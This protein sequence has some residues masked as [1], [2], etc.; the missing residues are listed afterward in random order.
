ME[1][2]Y[3]F[4][5]EATRWLQ[6]TYPS[7]E[8]F[9]QF[10]S[11]IGRFEFYL[12]FLTLLYWCVDKRLGAT[13]VYL[14]ILSDFSNAIIKH[15]FRDPRP[16]WL[17]PAVGL[18]SEDSYGI[19]SGH[20]QS[21]TVVYFLIAAWARRSWGW[22]VAVLLA[23][24]MVLS[25]VYL[26]VHFVHDA[27][28]G[29]FLGLLVLAGYFIWQRYLRA[30][31]QNRILGQRLL[32]AVGLPLG[33]VAVYIVVLLLLGAPN[34]QV[35]WADLIPDAER[36]AMESVVTNFALLLGVGVGLLLE[37]SRVR[38]TVDGSV[39]QR[40]LRYLV[41]IVVTVLIWYGL[42]QLFPREPLEVAL[43]LR[44]LR[45]LLLGL[46]GV[47][48]GPMVFVRLGLANARPEPE[49]SMKLS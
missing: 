33:F 43:P 23:I 42:G 21:A 15:S 39:V 13:L 49:I 10:I 22:V 18:S 6:A 29:V 11:N 38:F 41:G 31:F 27:L 26:G 36:T 7:L 28:V 45:Y 35:P 14:L 40:I 19:P 32:V 4:G 12:A 17:D 24:F 44:F 1:P 9:F 48:F 30:H 20:T 37:N 47:Y 8:S 5:L 25:R 34:L 2:L 3:E 16:Y 46:W